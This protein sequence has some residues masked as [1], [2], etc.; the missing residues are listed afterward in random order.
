MSE[1]VQLGK[2]EK[3]ITFEMNKANA[4]KTRFT[5][6]EHAT[7][8]GWW[9]LGIISQLKVEAEATKRKED[10]LLGSSRMSCMHAATPPVSG[11]GG[12][13]FQKA[14]KHCFQQFTQ[15]QTTA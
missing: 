15:L 7:Q 8:P 10:L 13:I 5:A 6:K 12:G 11:L 4:R 9:M 14:S 1:C 3:F 2:L